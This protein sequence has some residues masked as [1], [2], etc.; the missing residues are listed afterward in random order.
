M[1][2][3]QGG[4]AKGVKPNKCAS[5]KTHGIFWTQSGAQA[6]LELLH[7]TQREKISA[8]IP[9]A[10]GNVHITRH[11]GNVSCGAANQLWLSS[12]EISS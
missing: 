3:E 5:Q 6:L 9:Q 4:E 11:W 7:Q 8:D 12:Q 2:W 1:S 10:Q